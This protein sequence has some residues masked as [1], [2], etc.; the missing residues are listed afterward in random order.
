MILFILFH[1][2]WFTVEF[3]CMRYRFTYEIAPVFTIMEAVLLKKMCE[4][5]GWREAEAD[6]IFLPGKKK[7]Y[8]WKGIIGDSQN[9]FQLIRLFLSHSINLHVHKPYCWL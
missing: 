3:L 5:I 7:V 4:I 1:V 8:K 6:G 9:V 2:T